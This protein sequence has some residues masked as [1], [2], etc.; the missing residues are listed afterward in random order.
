MTKNINS[1]TSNGNKQPD[2]LEK[3]VSLCKRRGFV[4]PGSEIYGGFAGTYDYGHYG[5][6][7][8][9]NIQQSW[10]QHFVE[11]QENMYGM[12]AAILM[13]QKVWRASGHAEGF[14]DPLV[15]CEECKKQF[16]IDQLDFPRLNLK[17]SEKV[18]PLCPDCA[19]KL[20]EARQFNMM[21]KT[22][23]GAAENEN[24]VSYLRPETAQGMF[25]NFKNAL[26][27]YH[28]KLPFGLAQIGKAFR[29]E[30]APRDFLFRTREFEQ[31]EIEYFVN[32]KDW[33]KS[34][35]D[36]RLETKK[37]L[38][39]IGLASEKIHELEV[40][41]GERAHYSKR[42]IDFEYD[43][44]FGRNELYGLAY[45]TDFDLANHSRES[46]VSLEYL[47]EES[48]EKFIPHVIEPSFGLDRTFLAL[49][50]EAYTED[51]MNNEKRTYLKLSPKIA[52][53]KV[54]IFPLLR[55]KPALVKKAREVF[56]FL[57]SKLQVT[58]YMIEWD[59]NGN[60]GKRYRRQD[61]IGTP[62]TITCDFQTLEDDTVTVRDRDTGKQERV[63]IAE[64]VD[65]LQNKL[66]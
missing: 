45:R 66:A 30:I 4:F 6:A 14:A 35:E 61:E 60:I 40:P 25:A 12:D 54:A 39:E 2:L 1:S 62:A 18:Q 23:I 51:E 46:D 5:L 44:P 43:F 22:N 53:V 36:L 33:K 11:N 28:P 41:D 64:L 52:P 21:F 32:P 56:K 50:C 17:D 13:N 29:N 26:D 31:M 58:G 59:D 3:I 19:G 65:T 27:A 24:S 42:T 8:K 57:H 15:E 16:R 7:L 63:K 10:W 37:W 20:S 48:K 9:K 38:A 55:N 49:L 47:D 34:F